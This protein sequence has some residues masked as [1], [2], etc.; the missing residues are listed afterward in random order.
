MT[1]PALVPEQVAAVGWPRVAGLLRHANA[2]LWTW[3][4]AGL[5]AYLLLPW[6]AVQDANGLLAFGRTWGD[7]ATANGWLQATGFGR[8]GL[9]GGLLAVAAWTAASALAP[10]RRQGSVLV[11]AGFGG[12]L[13]LLAGG[14]AVGPKGWNF[15]V[16]ESAF[17]PL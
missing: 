5:M 13:A 10:G 15:A 4:A 8:W 17:G 2:P 1:S 14:F 9:L 3:S 11:A 12:A 6:Y 16:L 7:P